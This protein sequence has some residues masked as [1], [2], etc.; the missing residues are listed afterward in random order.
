MSQYQLGISL[1]GIIYLHR[2]TDPKM[3]GSALRNFQMFEKICGEKALKN[4][5]LLTTMW[6][7]LKD[8]TEGFDRDQELR[9]DFWSLMEEN[10]S[11]IT[12]FDGSKEMAEALIA[13]LY[14]K[15]PIVLSIQKELQ[16]EGKRLEQTSAGQLL[17]PDINSKV[18]RYNEHIKYLEGRL[19]DSRQSDQAQRAELER[20]RREY[21]EY[22]R[23]EESKRQK[24]R[25]RVAQEMEQEIKNRDKSES[26]WKDKFQ[27]FATLTGVAV[28]VVMNLLPV[29]GIS[30]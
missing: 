25:A 23:R 27:L 16:D 21:A 28:N 3:Q 5:V 1:K 10:G 7:K 2:I 14:A 11:Y 4:V 19:Q 20:Q 8:E 26:S 30:I 17:L 6:D 18:D 12:K 22:R 29:L 13:M 15:E 24:L 9:E